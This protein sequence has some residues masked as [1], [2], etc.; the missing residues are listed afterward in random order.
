MLCP[1]V[2]EKNQENQHWIQLL[3]VISWKII[4]KFNQ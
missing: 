4:L 2:I 3:H 1:I